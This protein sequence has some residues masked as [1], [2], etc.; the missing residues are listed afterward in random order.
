MSIDEAALAIRFRDALS[1]LE[2]N[3]RNVSRT[4]E[5]AFLTASRADGSD[6]VSERHLALCSIGQCREFAAALVQKY[7]SLFEKE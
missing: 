7:E 2:P 5:I 4:A 3:I 6:D 1:A